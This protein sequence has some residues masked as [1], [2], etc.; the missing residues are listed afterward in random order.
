[1]DH[2]VS[3]VNN[4]KRFPVTRWLLS[5]ATSGASLAWHSLNLFP[6]RDGSH[7]KKTFDSDCVREI[8]NCSIRL[9]TR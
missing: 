3:G 2:G 4:Y 5:R 7:P 6:P 9:Q 8:C 1:M